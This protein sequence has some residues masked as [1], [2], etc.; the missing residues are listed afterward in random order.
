MYPN[1]ELVSINRGSLT[2]QKLGKISM[3]C[4]YDYVTDESKMEEKGVVLVI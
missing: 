2:R 3:D 4:E 1:L